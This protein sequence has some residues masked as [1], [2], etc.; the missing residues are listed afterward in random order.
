MWKRFLLVLF[1]VAPGCA[2]PKPKPIIDL[3]HPI[4]RHQ[5]KD[6]TGPCT[7]EKSDARIEHI[8]DQFSKIE[9]YKITGSIPGDPSGTYD[10]AFVND[11]KK[12]TQGFGLRLSLH[13]SEWAFFHSCSDQNGVDLKCEVSDHIVHSG[14]DVEEKLRATLT[15]SYLRGVTAPRE[16]ALYGKRLNITFFVSECDAKALL[17]RAARLRARAKMTEKD[18]VKDG[19]NELMEDIRHQTEK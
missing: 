11:M 9:G 13:S 16:I 5:K 7:V 2:K 19:F 3:D 4:E 17:G 10:L 12:K 8:Y 1:L 18:S 14:K 6:G 15:E